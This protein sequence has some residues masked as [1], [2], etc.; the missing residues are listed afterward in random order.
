MFVFQNY[1]TIVHPRD[2]NPLHFPRRRTVAGFKVGLGFTR[3]D[4]LMRHRF[5]RFIIYLWAAAVRRF[6]FSRHLL[7]FQLFRRSRTPLF[8][9]V[10]PPHRDVRVFQFRGERRA[11]AQ[12]VSFLHRGPHSFA[13]LAQR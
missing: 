12:P 1:N 8:R 5:F 2:K 7:F 6:P 4:R 3:R 13:Q 11:I 10:P 9:A